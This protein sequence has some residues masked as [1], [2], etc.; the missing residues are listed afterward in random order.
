MQVTLINH[1]CVK[2]AIGDAVILCD[3]WLS[4]PAFNNGW[5][6]LI[7]TP[8]D[9][10][11]RDGRRHPYLGVARASGSLRAEI[12]HRHFGRLQID[13]RAVPGDARPAREVVH[14]VARL[15]RDRAA[16][17]ARADDRRRAHHLRRQRILR[18]MAARARRHAF[19]AQSQRL[20]RGRRGRAARDRRADRSDRPAAHPVQLRGLERR[21]RQ[22]AF[23]RARG[24]AQ[25]RNDRRAGACAQ[26][27][28]RR[29]VRELRVL[30]QRGKFLPQRSHQPPGRR[31]GGDRPGRRRRPRSCFPAK[32]GTRARRTTTRRRSRPSTKSTARSMP[33]PCGRPARA[34]RCNG[35][36]RN[37]PNTASARSSRTR[38]R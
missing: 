35:S 4:G 28:P 5:D 3:P 27:A 2:I 29:A 30:L 21:A 32:R 31:R 22:R 15:R 11:R 33:C 37:S 24:A 6:L 16:R 9:A 25:A 23:P 36:N 12:L 10:R 34:C 38:K 8:L 19:G 1:A 17:P 18:F 7:P 13:S 14:R 20:R 26:A